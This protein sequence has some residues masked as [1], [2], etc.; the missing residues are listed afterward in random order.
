MNTDIDGSFLT[1]CGKPLWIYDLEVFPN[2]FFANFTNGVDRRQFFVKDL[3]TLGTFLLDGDKVLG[4]FNNL[5]Y[6]DVMLRVIVSGKARTAAD[7]YAW[8]NRIINPKDKAD[9]QQVFNLTYSDT[10]WA[11]SI[12]AFQLVNKKGSLKEWC[13]KNGAARVVDS[14]LPFDQPLPRANEAEII[15]YCNNDI[16]STVGMFRRYWHLVILRHNL[17]KIYKLGNR[18]YTLSEAGIAQHAFMT[19]HRRRTGRTAAEV[20]QAKDANKDNRE[21]RWP[22]TAI[23]S[24]KVRFT[25]PE[26]KEFFKTFMTGAI[27]AKD[28][29]GISWGLDE[30]YDKPVTLAGVPFKIGVGG[31]HSVDTP[32][33]YQ[34]DDDT[35]IIDLDVTSYYPSMILVEKLAPKQM[36]QDFLT[37]MADLRDRRVAAKRSG[38]KSTNEALKIVI[39]ST[40]GKL[41]DYYCPFRSVP[42]ALRVTINGQLMLLMLVEMLH[43]VGFGIM[44]ANTDGVT[45]TMPRTAKATLDD[46]VARWQAA[47]Y[48]GLEAVEYA[49]VCRRDVNCYIAMTTDGKIKR[50][51]TMNPEPDSGK[52]DNLAAKIAAEK[53]LLFGDPVERTLARLTDGKL[54]LYYQRV[55]NGGDVYHGDTK[56]GKTA[57]WYIG[58]QGKQIRR[59]K[60]GSNPANIPNGGNAVLAMDIT[61]WDILG[62]PDDIDL[63]AYAAEAWEIIHSVIGKPPKAKKPRKTKKS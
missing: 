24:N 36:G 15:D 9:E 45:F 6:D 43:K 17:D 8:S 27:T 44:S 57:R 50:K 41:N 14:P 4:G 63:S 30:A 58:K 12:D 18:I 32:G 56:I 26:F 37:T 42:D 55:K 35:A 62:V 31:L 25:T 34:S 5:G 47:T 11:F 1:P 60:E 23:V 3:D 21:R 2:W 38:D 28:P 48:H 13:C 46:I 39:N 7:L 20:R 61:D 16:D 53:Y 29:K 49:K 59:V 10:P 22:L 40:F 52:W 54:F 51:G 33:I 19:L